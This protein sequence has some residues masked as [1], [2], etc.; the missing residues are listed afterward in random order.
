MS[1]L[2]PLLAHA[3]QFADSAG[4]CANAS[5]RLRLVVEEL[6]SNTVMHG[7][8]GD[9]ATPVRLSLRLD[10]TGLLLSYDDRAPAFDP[11][12]KSAG[13]QAHLQHDLAQRPVGQLG[14]PLVLGL[15]L[16][17]DYRYEQGWNCLRLSLARSA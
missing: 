13:R 3:Q 16:R 10:A 1:N 2:A 17:S 4:L 9:A 5:L 12:V 14:L 11:T 6:F 15:A 7:C 8:G